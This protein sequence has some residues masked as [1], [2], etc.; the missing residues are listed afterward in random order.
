[1][2]AHIPGGQI[3]TGSHPLLNWLL[4]LE[5]AAEA[6][7]AAITRV[8]S[9]KRS[10]FFIGISL[11]VRSNPYYL[12]NPVTG[13]FR[14]GTI[15]I[16]AEFENSYFCGKLWKTKKTSSGNFGKNASQ[17]DLATA[18]LYSESEPPIC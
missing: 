2:T 16:G 9:T 1:L 4:A 7:A 14:H 6:T 11:S 13:Y 5:V 15:P 18:N 8:A 10:D 3:G 12:R 17:R